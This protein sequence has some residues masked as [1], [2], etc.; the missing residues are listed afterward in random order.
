MQSATPAIL[1]V[2][3]DPAARGVTKDILQRAGYNVTAAPDG[4]SALR[5]LGEQEF[6]VVVTD[7]RMRM[8]DGIR[9]LEEAR[10]QPYSPEVILLTGYGSM[11]SAVAA[12]RL[13]AYDYLLKP[14]HPDQLV[15]GVQRALYHR[16]E[17]ISQ[18]EVLQRIID[19]ASSARD[20]EPIPT[21][22]RAIEP[23]ID[24]VPPASPAGRR[25]PMRRDVIC[26]W[27]N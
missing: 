27:V 14:C 18:A 7:I 3:D 26:G 11:E 5:L 2:E 12:L 4:E 13:G 25:P 15:E 19:I 17:Q 21:A 22:A 10:K 6:S 1:L 23:Q 20:L 24:G 16:A 8:V 9:V